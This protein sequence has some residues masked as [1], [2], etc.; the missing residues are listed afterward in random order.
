MGLRVTVNSDDPPLFNTTLTE[1][2]LRLAEVFGLSEE[3][4]QLLTFNAVRSTFLPAEER[5][6]MEAEF[7]E[8]FER[9]NSPVS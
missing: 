8:Q 7:V 6:K 4:L 9:L 1:E 2:Y 5:R 3:D